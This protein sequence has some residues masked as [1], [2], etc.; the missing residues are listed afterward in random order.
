MDNVSSVGDAAVSIERF[1]Q[2]GG[3]C[4]VLLSRLN[5]KM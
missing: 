2:P 4:G 3:Q 1:N 5:D